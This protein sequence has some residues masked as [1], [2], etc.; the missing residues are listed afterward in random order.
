MG[1]PSQ[2]VFAQVFGR[3]KAFEPE[4]E[5]ISTYLERVHLYFEANGIEDNKQPS[6]LLTVIGAKNYSIIRSLVAP[7]LPKDK[8]FA[9]LETV[10]K[11]HFQPKPL[12]IAERF[13]FYQRSQV[14][15]ESVQ[16]FIAD[17]RRLAISC[18]FGDF[19]NQALRDRFVCGLKA[20][21]IQKKLLAEDNLTIARALELAR[22]MEVAAADAKELKHSSSVPGSGG[23]ILHAAHSG[24]PANTVCLSCG[25]SDH[26]RR[27]CRF[28]DA[29][30]H[31]PGHIAPA[32]KGSK[33][34]G[35]HKDH[36]NHKGSPRAR[37][38]HHV[39]S[40][41]GQGAEEDSDLGILTVNNQSR[42]T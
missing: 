2:T 8:T 35:N 13:R 40:A 19:L 17:L 23:K 24:P 26:D 10:L 36:Q 15:G 37:K 42:W 6:V 39:D 29:K 25:K 38:T 41:Q 3:L 32:C 31:A 4:G 9:E 22:G 16:D 18:E 34:G 7:A 11:A 27:V 28:R 30:C 12:L 20:E 1:D 5:N 14:A 21:N 33:H